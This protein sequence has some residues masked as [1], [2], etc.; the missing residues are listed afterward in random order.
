MGSDEDYLISQVLNCMK[1][2]VAAAKSWMIFSKSAFPQSFSVLFQGYKMECN[3]QNLIESALCLCDLI[4]KF[5]N[6]PILIN[7]LKNVA[8]VLST[9]SDDFLKKIFEQLP[10]DIKY[11]VMLI[12]TQ[13]A[14]TVEEHCE[15]TLLFLKRM[16]NARLLQHGSNI[17]DTLL[18]AED[19]PGTPVPINLFRKMLVCDALPLILRVSQFDYKFKIVFQLLQKAIEF[20]VCCMFTPVTAQEGSIRKDVIAQSDVNPDEGWKPLLGLL[21]MVA[22][23]YRWSYPEMFVTNF[24]DTSLQQL[25]S[26]LKRK[27]KTLS[28]LT[29]EKHRREEMSGYEEAYFCLIVTFF[30]YL[31]SF[32]RLMFPKSFPNSNAGTSNYILMEG[33]TF[34]QEEC[35]KTVSSEYKK[36]E[37]GYVVVSKYATAEATNMLVPSFVTTVECWELLHRHQ[38]LLKEFKCLCKNIQLETWPVYQ[39]FYMD[40]LIYERGHRDAVDHLTRLRDSAADHVHKNKI[41]L[42]LASC[43]HFVND[44]KRCLKILFEVIMNLPTTSS[45]LSKPPLSKC[46]A[47]FTYFMG[48]NNREIIQYCASMLLKQYK[49]KEITDENYKDMSLG[50]MLVL[51]QYDMEHEYEML[52]KIIDIIKQAK[53]FCFPKFFNYIINVDILEEIAYLATTNGGNV[54]LEILSTPTFQASKQRAVT[55]GINKGAKDDLKQAFVNQMSRCYD[56]IDNLF[57]DFIKEEH[58]LLLR[59]LGDA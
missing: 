50:Y 39:E 30:Y 21:E 59:P 19:R 29:S 13:N 55:R 4:K 18:T 35:S 11:E 26:L 58:S 2:D 43:Y 41:V 12:V 3:E 49:Y 25:L 31:H 7:E 8:R 27:N 51:M 45:N 10:E 15:L 48:Y 32:G 42:Q 9:D 20:Y 37:R 36:T 53:S 46:P 28:S 1:S 56:N 52:H 14:Q 34:S 6:E 33:I 40:M 47:R 38:H 24:S 23:R 44:Y 5:P 17:I 22:L 57:I 54:N 16:P